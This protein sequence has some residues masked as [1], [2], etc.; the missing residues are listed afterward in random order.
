M[1]RKS[2]TT[3]GS[4]GQHRSA[5]ATGDDGELLGLAISLNAVFSGLTG[6]ILIGGAWGLDGWLGAPA[7][8]LAALGLGLL[9]FAARLLWLLA[10]PDTLVREARQVI[11]ADVVWVLG[12]VLVV[13]TRD[14]LTSAGNVALLAVTAV[15]AGLAVMQ[16]EGLR[17]AARSETVTGTWPV[18]AVV[19]REIAADPER[20]WAA[21]ADAGRYAAFADGIAT[22]EIEGPPGEGMVRV[23]TDDRGDS[24]S[25][26]C[27]L[28]EEGHRYRMTVDVES[29]P[30][31]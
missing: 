31:H 11:A 25:E 3:A 6:L 16:L 22:T 12:A 20:V 5:G 10:H 21:V 13:I 30:W 9:F 14:V 2:G 8:A 4:R 26:R 23:C 29:Y 7:W 17:R 27:T 28:W 15:V 19:R 18:S 1:T 24:W